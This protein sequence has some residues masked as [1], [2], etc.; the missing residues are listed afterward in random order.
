M[1]DPQSGFN[2]IEM[3]ISLAFIGA[4]G[5]LGLPRILDCVSGLRVELAAGEMVGVLHL[6]RIYS[7]RHNLKAAVKF[8]AEPDGV[9][10]H[11]LYRDGD[12]DGVRNADISQGVDPEIRSPRR[13]AHLGQ[14]IR[15]GF[16]RGG[17]P[18]RD[19]GNPKRRLSRLNDPI[20]FGNSDLAT[21][22]PRGTASPGTIYLTD[23]QHHLAA[24]R[25]NNRSGKISVLLYDQK[26]EIWR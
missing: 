17:P 7:A 22:N 24:V 11:S 6:A 16:P 4:L 25:V 15:F 5:A 13:L 8:R 19:P 10:T 18:P 21:F 20:R 3:A 23:G 9:V 12:G 1:R 14:R 26:S 2:L